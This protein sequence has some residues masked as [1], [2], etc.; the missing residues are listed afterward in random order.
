MEAPM[1]RQPLLAALAA[2]QACHA[3]AEEAVAERLAEFV[4]STPSCFERTH[5]AG[6]VTGSALVVSRALD[7]VLLTHHRKLNLWVQ[8]G[9]HADGD[10]RIHQVAWREAVEESGLRELR[11]V[12]RRAGGHTLAPLDAVAIGEGEALPT[13]FDIDIHAIPARRDEPE[14][15]HYDVRYL[16]VADDDEPLVISAESHDLRWL[17]LAQARA[18]TQE[19]SMVRMF[20]KVEALPRLGAG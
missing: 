3:R 11:L 18:L 9:G 7:R 5:L 14:H 12:L 15:L 8:L 16:L 4:L 6:H 1:N 20:D 17:T 2:Y 10:H 19:P 13:P